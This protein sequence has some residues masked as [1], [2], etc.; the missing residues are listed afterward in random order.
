MPQ[1]AFLQTLVV[2]A[3]VSFVLVIVAFPVTWKAGWR[4]GRTT[5]RASLGLLVAGLVGTL[6]LGN[7]NG[8][9]VTFRSTLGI[10][11]AIQMGVFFLIMYS[12]AFLFVSR[13]ITT[14][15]AEAA[16]EDDIDA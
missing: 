3:F 16:Q 7:S 6:V 15:A 11:G 9:L 5:V 1:M 8:E 2:V 14:L 12:T 10:D 4:A 13:Y